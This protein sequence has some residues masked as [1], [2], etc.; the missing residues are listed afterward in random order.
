MNFDTDTQ[1][2]HKFLSKYYF[3]VIPYYVLHVCVCVLSH[4]QLFA[5]PWT[6]AYQAPLSM[7]FCRQEYWSGLPFLSLGFF[8][9]QGSNPGLLHLLHWQVDSFP[10]A[11]PGKPCTMYY[12]HNYLLLSISLIS[13]VISPLVHEEFTKCTF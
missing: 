3:C 8:L 13:I 1:R 6:V 2:N 10:L 12:F 7:G 5:T 9:T 11:W 4:A